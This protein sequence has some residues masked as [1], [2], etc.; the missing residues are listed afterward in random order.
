MNFSETIDYLY[1]QLPVFQKIGAAAFKPKLENTEKLCAHLGNPQDKFKS[2]HIAGTNGKGSTAHMISSIL[3]ESG[4]K[5]GLYTSPHLKSFTERI[6]INGVEISQ[7]YVI[8]FVEENKQVIETWG[9]SFFE[10]TVGL[11]FSYFA[12]HNVDFAVIETG[13]GGRLDSTNV[14]RPELSIITN[15]SMDHQQYLGDSLEKIAS[16]KAGIIKNGVPAIIGEEQER[17]KPIFEQAATK[18]GAN[19]IFAYKNNLP[20]DLL[21]VGYQYKNALTA[22]TAINELSKKHNRISEESVIEGFRDF[23]Q[24]TGLKGRWQVIDS[25]PL[26][27]CDTGH[28]ADGIKEVLKRVSSSGKNQLHFVFGTVSDKDHSA[29]LNLLPKD[30]KYYFCTAKVPRALDG[31]ELYEK[32]KH[33]GLEGSVIHDVNEAI[34][35]ARSQA[36]NNDLVL[37]GGSTFVVADIDNL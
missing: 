36:D 1:H 8:Q 11:C 16:E 6:K 37:I 17:I 27:V 18:V 9:L 28:N 2:I 32:A 19:L 22:H 34:Q 3:T 20:T 31:S 23:E 30:A 26:T 24:K 15:V 21:F 7:N 5:T 10:L 14:I 29:I 4:Y 12:D 35:V 25:N 33:V 13:M